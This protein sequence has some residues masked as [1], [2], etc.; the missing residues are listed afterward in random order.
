MTIPHLRPA[1]HQLI[2]D[3]LSTHPPQVAVFNGEILCLSYG[4]SIRRH[5]HHHYRG[6]HHNGHL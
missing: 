3:G 2:L 6:Q 4:D 5:R 1:E